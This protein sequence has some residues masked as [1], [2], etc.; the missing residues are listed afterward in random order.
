MTTIVLLAFFLFIAGLLFLFLKM[1]G[2]QFIQ[3]T[4]VLAGV[5]ASAVM[6]G[7]VLFLQ[8]RFNYETYFSA[9]YYQGTNFG[10]EGDES[11]TDN[12]L[13]L[14]LPGDDPELLEEFKWHLY[15]ALGASSSYYSV[16]GD[17]WDRQYWL[18]VDSERAQ[19]LLSRGYLPAEVTLVEREKDHLLI[20]GFSSSVSSKDQVSG[21]WVTHD[22]YEYEI[23]LGVEPPFDDPDKALK[24][25][26]KE[27]SLL[28]RDFFPEEYRN[29]FK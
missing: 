9:Q 17:L 2:N 15:E 14:V 25:L 5:F 27:V 3:I 6:I 8:A 22:S 21:E 26:G 24:N 19:L 29:E 13:E 4:I 7:F 20:Y 10:E 18:P 12:Y 23:R 1:K 16:E 11:W 28:V